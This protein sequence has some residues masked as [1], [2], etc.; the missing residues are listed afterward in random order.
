MITVTS[1]TNKYLLGSNNIICLEVCT[2]LTNAQETRVN[3]GKRRR[4]TYESIKESKS[5]DRVPSNAVTSRNTALKN[6]KVNRAI[7]RWSLSVNNVITNWL[8]LAWI[9]IRLTKLLDA[10]SNSKTHNLRD[11]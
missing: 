10:R 1:A 8:L 11:M 5:A 7:G 4:Q 3:S 6:K 9:A 2:I